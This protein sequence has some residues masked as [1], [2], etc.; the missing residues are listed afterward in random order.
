VPAALFAGGL[1]VSALGR[2]RPR[3][4]AEAFLAWAL[5]GQF[6]LVSLLWLFYDRYLLALVVPALALAVARQPVRRPR[7]AALALAA[8]ALLSAV[9]LRDH[10]ASARC[11]AQ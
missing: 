4:P 1:L 8:L 9:G 3:G 7:L 6:L 2:R 5:L 10:L 11:G